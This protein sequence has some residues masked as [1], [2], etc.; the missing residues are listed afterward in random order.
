MRPRD[1]WIGVALV[2]GAIVFHA[3]YPRYE[4]RNS[5]SYVLRIDRWTG[6]PAVLRKGAWVPLVS[7]T[8]DD[9]LAKFLRDHPEQK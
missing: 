5:S 1:W 7:A 3:M 8:A 9:E 2:V 4:V 6:N